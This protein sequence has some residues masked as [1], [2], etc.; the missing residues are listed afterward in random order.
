MDFSLSEEQIAIR[1]TFARFCDE[2]IRPQAEAVDEAEAFPRELFR[3][4]GELGFFGMRYPEQD[5]GADAG[6]AAC[7]LAVEELA[8]GSLSLAAACTMQS[9]MGTYFVQRFGDADHRKRLLWPALRGEKVGTICMTEPDAGSDLGGLR[10]RAEPTGGGWRLNGQKMWITS[11]PVADFFTVF[12]RVSDDERANLGIFLVERDNPGLMVG[13]SIRKLGVRASITSEV[14][15]ED[16]QVPAEAA[17]G[18]PGQG[19]QYLREILDEIRIITGALALGCARAALQDSLEYARSRVQFGRPISKFQ[20][21]RFKFADMDTELEAARHLVYYAAWR[22]EQGLPRTRE[23]A[24]AK[25]YASEAA[26]RVCEQAAR[27]MAAYGYAMEYPIQRYL[28]DIRFTLIGGGTS[29][30]MKLI[31]ARELGT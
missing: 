6:V 12:A 23:A 4:V 18:Q 28:R 1:D 30:M 21:I 7:C 19:M 16:C 5:G 14:A 29:E 13:R 15:L 26:A 10:T 2:Q 22:S 3:K 20:A 8:R 11:A 27:V 25:Y 17:L 31:I 9:L 24:I